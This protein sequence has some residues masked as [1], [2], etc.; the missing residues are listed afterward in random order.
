[1]LFYTKTFWLLFVFI[2]NLYISTNGLTEINRIKY[3]NNEKE[4]NYPYLKISKRYKNGNLRRKIIYERLKLFK[5]HL[6]LQNRFS[7]KKTSTLKNSLS[8]ET[9]FDVEK[10]KQIFATKHNLIRKKHHVELLGVSKELEYEAQRYA[11]KLAS[12]N[13]GLRHDQNNIHHGENL[14]YGSFVN[15]PNEEDLSES[16]LNKFYAE[17]VYYNYNSFNPQSYHK[18]GHFTQMIWKSS[19]EFG[20]GVGFAKKFIHR[21]LTKTR[22]YVVIR[23]NPEGNILSE[24][25]FKNNVL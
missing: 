14:Y 1:M 12:I 7:L 2:N 18:Y 9:N 10:F 22:I 21:G 23:Y 11:D 16:I 3:F 8:L 15:I 25:D 6:L 24:K 4:Y 20:I 5:K 13:N 17:I 19:T